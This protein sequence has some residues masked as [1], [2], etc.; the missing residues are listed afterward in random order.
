M[1][2]LKKEIDEIAADTVLGK[3]LHMEA[4]ILK[5]TGSIRIEGHFSGNIS[6]DGNLFVDKGG[7]VEGD[8]NAQ[9]ALIAGNVN[10]NIQCSEMLRLTSSACVNGDIESEFIVV[11]EGAIFNGRSKMNTRNENPLGLEH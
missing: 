2:L 1:K 8:I 5:G 11:D 3:G 7:F 9:I 10:G 6:L 4:A